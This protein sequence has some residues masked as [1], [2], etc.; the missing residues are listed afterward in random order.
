MKISKIHQ[1]FLLLILFT[2]LWFIPPPVGLTAQAWHLFAVFLA[3]IVGVV[4]KVLPVGTI[5]ILALTVTTLTQTIT[6]EG[7]LSKF[8]SPT[9]WLIFIAFILARGFIK[10]GL[11]SRIAYCFVYLFGKRTLGLGYGLVLTEF[12]LAPFIPSN[13]ARGGG[14]VF[15]LVT[16]ISNEYGS[17]PTSGTQRK[18]GAFLLQIC[19]QANIITSAMFLTAMAANPLI[20]SF[21]EQ[22]GVHVTWLG[23]TTASIVPGIASLLA[24]PLVVYLIFPPEVTE[25]PDAR[26]FASDKL[27]AMGALK[28]EERIMILVFTLLLSLWVL[29]PLVDVDATSAAF[30]GLSIL[31]LTKVLSWDD[32]LS[33]KNAWNTFVWLTTLLMLTQNLNELGFMQW[34]VDLFKTMVVG[35]SWQVT[36][37]LTALIYFYS[38]YFFASKTARVTALYSALIAATVSSGAPAGLAVYVLAFVSSLSAC[39]THYSTSAGPVFFG[40][41]YVP[42]AKWWQIGLV[43]SLVQIVIW[44]GVGLPWWKFI[45]LW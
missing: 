44:T 25:T 8:S 26:R 42:F 34:F 10:S 39:L 33:E 41:G 21:A 2:I 35:L 15:P 38:H 12:I 45:G 5:A 3:T 30:L 40:A 6:I 22:V 9:V 14:I 19:F 16:S 23:W 18:I 27:A 1:K 36:L 43:V 11:G 31:L 32:V 24:V 37:A 4:S 17:S 7:A 29:G 13:T 28:R 20:A